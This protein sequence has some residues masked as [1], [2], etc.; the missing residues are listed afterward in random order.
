MLVDSN[1][2][3]SHFREFVKYPRNRGNR[4]VEVTGIEPAPCQF[5]VD[6]PPQRTPTH[7]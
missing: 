2:S 7:G 4:E 3:I 5:G 1:T 6:E